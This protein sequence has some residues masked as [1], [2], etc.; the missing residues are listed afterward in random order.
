MKILN[1]FLTLKL[2]SL[3]ELNLFLTLIASPGSV[4]SVHVKLGSFSGKKYF[5]KSAKKIIQ[6]RLMVVLMM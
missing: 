2:P 3:K 1:S 6:S 4:V 5:I